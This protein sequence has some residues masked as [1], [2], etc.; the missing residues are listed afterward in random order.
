MIE[1]YSQQVRYKEPLLLFQQ[2]RA[3][4]L[5]ER[6]RAGGPGV[7]EVCSRRAASPSATSTTTAASTC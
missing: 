3:R 4:K 2:R 1:S 5:R 7:H 6:Q